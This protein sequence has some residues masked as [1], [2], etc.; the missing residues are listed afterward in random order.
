MKHFSLVD[1]LASLQDIALLQQEHFILF[2]LN[3]A[4]CVIAKSMVFKGT[5]TGMAVHPRE[6]FNQAIKDSARSIVVAH[7]HPSGVVEPSD[8]DVDFTQ[9]LVS[10]GILLGIPLEDHIIVGGKKHFSFQGQG[11]IEPPFMFKHQEGKVA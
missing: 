8:E 10:G 4:H 1:I 7:N 5:L 9:Q 2:S 3:S 6:V 11:F